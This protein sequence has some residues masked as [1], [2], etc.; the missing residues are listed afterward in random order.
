MTYTY[1]GGVPTISADW[2]TQDINV[3]TEAEAAADFIAAAEDAVDLASSFL[4]NADGW[5]NLN[6]ALAQAQ[7]SLAQA[8]SASSAS[9]KLAASRQAIQ[10]AN[11][12]IGALGEPPSSSWLS[13]DYEQL[14]MI[15]LI[16]CAFAGVSGGIWAAVRR[17][18][19]R[20]SSSAESYSY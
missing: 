5:E 10:S 3:I 18:R 11:E 17:S 15:I 9:L 6:P 19:R 12:V 16:A 4:E 20:H 1:W 7:T 13:L 14:L 8:K 2:T